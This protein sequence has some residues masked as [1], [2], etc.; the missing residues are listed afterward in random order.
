MSCFHTV[1]SAGDPHASER[2]GPSCSRT[3]GAITLV[4]LV[5]AV[6]GANLEQINVLQEVCRPAIARFVSVS[7]NNTFDMYISS[8][9]TS[10]SK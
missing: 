5:A 3:Q 2:I 9:V 6:K 1:V 10:V 7:H 8:S 4:G